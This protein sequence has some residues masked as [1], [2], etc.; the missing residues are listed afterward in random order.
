[1]NVTDQRFGEIIL[2][3]KDRATGIPAKAATR[4]MAFSEQSHI[5]TVEDDTDIAGMLVELVTS[6]GFRAISASNGADMDRLLS[7]QDFDLIVLDAMLPG[8]DGFSICQRLRA[9][10]TV[11]ILMLTALHEDVDDLQGRQLQRRR[12]F[13]GGDE[14]T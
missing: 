9:D 12:C 7:R 6:N 11:P 4:D 10:R 2:C 14:V 8:E 3:A 5:L 1:V 13:A